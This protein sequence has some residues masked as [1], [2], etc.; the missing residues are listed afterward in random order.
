M[1]NWFCY[2]SLTPD[3][4][5]KYAFSRD[6]QRLSGQ[7]AFSPRDVFQNE[8]GT[9]SSHGFLSV[10][11]LFHDELFPTLGR[12]LSRIRGLF[13]V[14][15]EVTNSY[16]SAGTIYAVNWRNAEMRGSF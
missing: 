14:R 7:W 4:E 3:A 10:T 9:A 12:S 15:S 8:S 1:R 13:P 6:W 5:G 2:F 16:L 11:T